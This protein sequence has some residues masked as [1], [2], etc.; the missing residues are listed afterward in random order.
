[1]SV[2]LFFILNIKINEL[3]THSA[4]DSKEPNPIVIIIKKKNIH[5]THG[6]GIKL[7]A[8]GYTFISS[9]TYN[10]THWNFKILYDYALHLINK[11]E[12]IELE[13]SSNIKK[14]AQK[15]I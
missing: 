14:F 5:Q 7:K 6:K 3:K 13:N 1:M 9:S 8:S 2:F 10:S 15:I 12:K 4:K 11:T